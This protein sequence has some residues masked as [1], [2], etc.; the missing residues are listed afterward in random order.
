MNQQEIIE[1][2]RQAGFDCECEEDCAY[3]VLVGVD[4]NGRDCVKLPRAGGL[5]PLDRFIESVPEGVET[6][7]TFRHWLVYPSS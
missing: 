2:A 3:A 6:A 4:E 7:S 1:K 5:E